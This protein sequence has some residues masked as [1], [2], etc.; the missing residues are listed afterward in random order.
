MPPNDL[1]FC[2]VLDSDRGESLSDRPACRQRRRDL[3]DGFSCCYKLTGEGKRQIMAYLVPG[4]F[5]DLHVS[6]LN[7]MDHTFATLSA[8][9]V[10]DISRDTVL[11]M[12]ERP[13]LARAL[14]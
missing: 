12:T 11:V 10:S 6:V 1:S 13:L 5:C 14:W 7:E 8:Y 2:R 4:D 9:R 3:L